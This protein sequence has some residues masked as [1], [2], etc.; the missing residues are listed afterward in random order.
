MPNELET[1]SRL[2]EALAARDVGAPKLPISRY[3]A[4]LKAMA[5]Y[6]EEHWEPLPGDHPGLVVYA[7]FCGDYSAALLR[8]AAQEIAAAQAAALLAPAGAK[9]PDPAVVT[10][11]TFV[12]GELGAAIEAVLDDDK[13]E[14]LDQSYAL[15][16]SRGE[17][18]S[19]A[20]TLAQSLIDKAAIAQQ[21]LPR[22][23]LLADFDDKLIDV[24]GQLGDV[25]SASAPA[26]AKAASAAIARRNRLVAVAEQAIDVL[27]RGAH[28]AFRAAPEFLDRMPT[29]AAFTRRTRKPRT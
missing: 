19:S 13:Q 2:T 4:Y 6:W 3:V 9:D 16:K 26:G 10:E 22:L 20:W 24:A 28:Y 14:D 25:L 29:R 11:A 12:D 23:K 8:A 7:P 15:A 18:D 17:G 21:L 27:E 1:L 5:T